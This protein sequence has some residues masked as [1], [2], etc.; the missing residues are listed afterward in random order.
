MSLLLGFVAGW[1]EHFTGVALHSEPVTEEVAPESLL[2]CS[3]PSPVL[4]PTLGEQREP[5][6]WTRGGLT[7]GGPA[8]SRPALWGPGGVPCRAQPSWG[9]FYMGGGVPFLDSQPK[10]PLPTVPGNYL[11]Q[12]AGQAQQGGQASVP[13]WRLT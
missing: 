2:G 12:N 7:T 4:L 11:D 9:G 13:L 8:H 3:L 1:P 6:R 10:Q 5:Q